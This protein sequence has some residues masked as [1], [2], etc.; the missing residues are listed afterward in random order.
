MRTKNSARSLP[1]SPTSPK[2]TS[3]FNFSSLFRR[4]TVS[5]APKLVVKVRE[6]SSRLILPQ[7]IHDYILLQLEALHRDPVA[8]TCSTCLLRDIS[9]YSKVSKEWHFAAVPRLY[10]A[11]T[12]REG[13]FFFFAV[14]W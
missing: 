13:V 8:P 1:T 3:H 6:V 14:R 4:S 5:P 9:A 2:K 11:F 7:E 12:G 10:V